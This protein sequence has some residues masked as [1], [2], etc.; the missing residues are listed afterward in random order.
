MKTAIII[1]Y[2]LTLSLIS[3]FGQSVVIHK[4][5]LEQLGKNEGYKT[6]MHTTYDSTLSNIQQARKTI[7]GAAG[8]IQIVQEKVFNSLTNVSDGI[9]NVRTL[10]YISQ[11]AL[12]TLDNVGTAIS[13]AAG[14]PY[15]VDIVSKDATVFYERIAELTGFVSQFIMNESSDQMIKPTERDRF[16]YTVYRQIMVLDAISSNLCANLK[17]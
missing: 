10:G 1:S 4:D 9:K 6:T 2:F 16:L 11:Y 3:S 8:A 7:S 14:K 12:F 17:K 5:L 15:L 13:L